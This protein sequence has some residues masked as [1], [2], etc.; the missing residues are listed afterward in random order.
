[1][2]FDYTGSG[3]CFQT[4]SVA[5]GANRR[6]GRPGDSCWEGNTCE[7]RPH[8]DC[9]PDNGNR[10]DNDCC[11]RPGGGRPDNDNCD[12]PGG[13]RPDNDNCG[14]P[15]GGRPDNDNCDRP[16]GRPDNDNC[17]R[18]DGGRP[19]PPQPY[20]DNGDCCKDGTAAVL[21]MAM[22]ALGRN[23][24]V[25]VEITLEGGYTQTVTLGRGGSAIISSDLVRT[26]QG[27]V[28]ICEISKLRIIAESANDPEYMQRLQNELQTFIRRCMRQGADCNM[29][30]GGCDDCVE[31]LQNYIMRNSENIDALLFDGSQSATAQVIT[32]TTTEQVVESAQL[33]TDTASFISSAALATDT[34]EVISGID[35]AADEVVTAVE[36]LPTSLVSAVTIETA[37]ASAPV[38]VTEVEVVSSVTV[39]DTAEF[40]S[41]VTVTPS[42]VLASITTQT[43]EVVSG[44]TDPVTVEGVISGV[45]AVSAVGATAFNVPIITAAETGALQVIIP[46]GAF[47]TNIPPADVT[48]D[49]TAGGAGVS[50]G[51]VATVYGLAEE[52]TLLGGVTGTPAASTVTTPGTAVTAEV[53]TEV[54]TAAAEVVGAVEFTAVSGTL[55]TDAATAAVGSAAAAE[56]VTII[57][58][59]TSEFADI[60]AV[61][62]VTTVT[63]SELFTTDTAA[64]ISAAEL[65]TT[66]A[67]AVT[68]ASLTTTEID[69]IS[70]ITTSP[71]NVIS[72]T[73][74]EE[75]NGEII[76]AR[77]GIVAVDNTDGDISVYSS[78]SIRGAQTET[79][80]M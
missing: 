58:A 49:V 8:E 77:C 59:V 5:G 2:Y 54:T 22:S 51:G 78:C 76:G 80:P 65:T 48:R 74:A 43:A 32:G 4:L 21:A 36:L 44:F 66:E 31:A 16:G 30:R 62:E 57:T 64:V 41:D 1:M 35:I 45:T 27:A 28:P 33:T 40:A 50:Y 73:F 60:N 13:G 34:V 25:D 26:A 29:G 38:T 68:E 47:G 6:H 67:E 61:G 75:I 18:P 3:S 46:A 12:R 56:T 42:S 19:F 71:V 15:G 63:A 9:R 69:A 37:E 24:T 52:T 79:D 39:T 23:D 20:C 72:P 17:G 7:I 70:G 14:R 10:P 53:V 11:G 55:V